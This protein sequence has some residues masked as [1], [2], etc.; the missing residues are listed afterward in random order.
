MIFLQMFR[1]RRMQSWILSLV[2][3]DYLNFPTNPT[4]HISMPFLQ[5]FFD[6]I[7]LLP[8]V[9]LPSSLLR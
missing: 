6:G 2:K 5:K 3:G 8:Q 9:L 7:V 1:K 4:Y